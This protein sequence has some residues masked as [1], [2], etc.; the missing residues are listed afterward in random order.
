MSDSEN[1]EVENDAQATANGL[2]ND[3]NGNDEF[4]SSRSMSETSSFDISDNLSK[5]EEIL[6]TVFESNSSLLSSAIEREHD[7][8]GETCLMNDFEN[9]NENDMTDIDDELI[10]CD[11]ETYLRR[12]DNEAGIDLDVYSFIKTKKITSPIEP[13]DVIRKSDSRDSGFESAEKPDILQNVKEKIDAEDNC[14]SLTL[15]QEKDETNSQWS[16]TPVDIVG[17]FEQEVKRE[18]GLLMNG[19]NINTECEY[20]RNN[21]V[22]GNGSMEKSNEKIKEKV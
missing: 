5:V 22:L 13:P 2:Q 16:I 11:L 10:T 6:R 4:D 20:K 12:Y 1:S 15:R 9:K 8:C 14:E 19:Y 17:D 21:S 18:L 3:Q 7:L